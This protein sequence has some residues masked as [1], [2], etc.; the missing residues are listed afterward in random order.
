MEF[1][2][3]RYFIE[4]AKIENFTTAA[5]RCHVTQPTLSHQI[6]KLEE[7]LGERL[8]QRNNRMVRLTEFGKRL[9]PKATDILEGIRQMH[10]EAH[11]FHKTIQG[12]LRIGAIPTIAPY[13]LPRLLRKSHDQ[14][15][16]LNFEIT[17][18][19]TMR[20]LDALRKGH[21][22]LAVL[23]RPLDDES[24]W[25]FR[26]VFEDEIL[27]TL[28]ISHP[29]S[30]RS[31]LDMSELGTEPMVLMQEAHCLSQQTIKYCERRGLTPKVAIESSQLDTV[32]GMVEAEMG[33]SFT[34]EMAIPHFQ[35]RDVRFLNVEPFPITRPISLIW[36]RHRHL[37]RSEK[38][39]I[40]LVL[41]D[42]YETATPILK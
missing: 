27:A 33:I 9:Y 8:F 40:D 17:E 20:L 35:N 31:S 38:A 28:P 14:Y 18:D 7:E 39:F 41:E 12:T 4:V 19:T 36:H 13:Y 23:S 3:L 11:A 29:L 15:P 32:I 16:K 25:I 42:A 34:P 10:E 1:Q 22:D 26:D 5:Q 37:V 21:V 24:E 30:D 6:K 2:Q